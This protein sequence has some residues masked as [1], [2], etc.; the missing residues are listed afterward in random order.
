MRKSIEKIKED[1]KEEKIELSAQK[2]LLKF[3]LELGFE[4]K[5]EEY[6][7]RQHSTRKNDIKNL[8][9]LKFPPFCRFQA[10]RLK[11]N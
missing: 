2:Y 8:I 11:E 7:R 6:L 9:L 5:G 1:P 4:K 10:F 3:Y